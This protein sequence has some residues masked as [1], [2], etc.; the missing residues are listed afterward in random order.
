MVEVKYNLIKIYINTRFRDRIR[1]IEEI[2]KN[3]VFDKI[4]TEVML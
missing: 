3:Y 2:K 1:S 4:D